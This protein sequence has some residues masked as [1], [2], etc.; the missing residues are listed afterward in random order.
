M[1]GS[2]NNLKAQGTHLQDIP[3]LQQA[4]GRGQ[5]HLAGKDREAGMGLAA[6]V[7]VLPVNEQGG[8]SGFLHFSV[9]PYVV[10]MAMGVDN[11]LDLDAFIFHHFEDL[12]P[13]GAGV[14][15]NSFFGVRAGS[16][17]A[18]CGKSPYFQYP[19]DHE[20]VLLF[21]LLPFLQFY[22]L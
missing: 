18:I 11:I 12:L 10:H 22:L 17:I 15:N 7:S 20:P 8:L 6:H 14:D 19:K 2:V 5:L 16:D 3:L 1:P 4:V 9:G 13:C 21:L